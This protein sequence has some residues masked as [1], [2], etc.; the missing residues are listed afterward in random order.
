MSERISLSYEELKA[1]VGLI[2]EAREG[3]DEDA[4]ENELVIYAQVTT[5]VSRAFAKARRKREKA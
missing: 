1:L 4:T 3:L 5:K 2:S